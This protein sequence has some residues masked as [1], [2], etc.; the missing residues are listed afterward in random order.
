M[1][2]RCEELSEQVAYYRSELGLIDDN[3]RAARVRSRF[4]LSPLEVRIA[5]RLYDAKGRILK[6]SLI[7]DELEIGNLDTL[8]TH[9]CRIRAK[10]GASAIQTDPHFG[11]SMTAD[12]MAQV[13]AALEPL[14]NA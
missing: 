10:M 12:G 6:L 1:C 13:L 8:K 4:K 3:T 7:C 5:L 11:Y 2:D 9:V 14:E